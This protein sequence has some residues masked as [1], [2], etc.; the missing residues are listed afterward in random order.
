MIARFL[1]I[2]DAV[3]KLSLVYRSQINHISHT[4][5][6]HENESVSPAYVTQYGCLIASSGQT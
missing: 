4:P 6:M 2:V 3:C 5:Y 1:F